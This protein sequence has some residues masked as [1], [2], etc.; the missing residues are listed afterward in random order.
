MGNNHRD[1][2]PFLLSALDTCPAWF[3]SVRNP[4]GQARKEDNQQRDHQTTKIVTLV[5]DTVEAEYAW[6]WQLF[7]LARSVYQA[8]MNAHIS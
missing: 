6:F 2:H 1:G 8:T 3:F 4:K 5:S 7:S